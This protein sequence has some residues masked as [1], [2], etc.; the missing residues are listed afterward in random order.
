MTL[1]WTPLTKPKIPSQ[2]WEGETTRNEDITSIV[3]AR[4]IGP[5]A[6]QALL[7]IFVGV[8][9][10][11]LSSQT[12]GLFFLIILTLFN[13]RTI[14]T[15][16]QYTWVVYARIEGALWCTP[17]PPKVPR[18]KAGLGSRRL[19]L[20]GPSCYFK[21]TWRKEGYQSGQIVDFESGTT[22]A[23]CQSHSVLQ[24]INSK[25][26]MHHKCSIT[27]VTGIYDGIWLHYTII[28][29]NIQGYPS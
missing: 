15:F 13:L 23:G 6:V 10:W 9:F 29:S 14:K 4:S 26:C 8:C 19:D 17:N 28:M 18:F 22:R 27:R 24:S 11:S 20:D 7:V 5:G 1:F 12:R 2:H 3:I 21:S 25:H 16:H